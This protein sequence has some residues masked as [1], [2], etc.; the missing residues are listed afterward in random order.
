MSAVAIAIGVIVVNL[1][2]EERGTALKVFMVDVDTCVD[3]IGTGA[4]TSSVIVG[5]SGAASVGA[6]QTR[7]TPVGTLLGSLDG[8]N[9]ILLDKVNL[10]RYISIFGKL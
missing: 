2:R 5:V 1:V 6:R 8:Y 9:C 4:L 3:Y 7:K 10:K